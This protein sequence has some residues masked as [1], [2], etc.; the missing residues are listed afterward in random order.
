MAVFV[1]LNITNCKEVKKLQSM[2]EMAAHLGYS[3]VA[4]NHVAEFG[5]KKAEIVKPIATKD[6]FPSPPTVQ[7]KSTPI[8]ILT[9]LTIVASDPSHCNVLVCNTALLHFHSVE[10]TDI[11]DISVPSPGLS[12][13]V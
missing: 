7:G 8:K 5:K 4:I 13:S 3:A 2:I 11:A 9:R 10:E 6:L 1:D 12:C